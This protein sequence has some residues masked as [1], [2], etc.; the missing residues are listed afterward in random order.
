MVID[1]RAYTFVPGT[2]PDFFEMF[3]KEGMA[4]QQRILGNFIGMYRTEI[5]NTNE[6]IHMWGYEDAAQRQRLRAILAKD[7]EFDAYVKK[8][9]KLITNQDVRLLIPAPFNPK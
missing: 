5:G 3:E 4:V 7:Q 9:R 8:A 2:V 6:V 1:F